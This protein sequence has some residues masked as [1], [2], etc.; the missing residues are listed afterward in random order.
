MIY[1]EPMDSGRDLT[2]PRLQPFFVGSTTLKLSCSEINVRAKAFAFGDN[3]DQG[4]LR[5]PI[6][7]EFAAQAPESFSISF[8]S[9]EIRGVT[10]KIVDGEQP[11]IEFPV[12]IELID[13][14]IHMMPEGDIEVTLCAYRRRNI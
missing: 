2:P 11:R 1:Y 6:P 10:A 12:P 13:P 9:G 3:F 5:L 4:P 8:P 7:H 14:T